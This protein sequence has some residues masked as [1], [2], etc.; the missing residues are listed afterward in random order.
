MRDRHEERVERIIGEVCEW[1]V[2]IM[3]MAFAAFVLWVASGA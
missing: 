3:L 2:I 1:T